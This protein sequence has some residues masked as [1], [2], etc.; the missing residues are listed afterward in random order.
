MKE[1]GAESR[2]E[3]R[4]RERYRIRNHGE[5]LDLAIQ[6]EQLGQCNSTIYLLPLL[7]QLTAIP[8]QR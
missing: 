5:L 6:Q 7:L 1:K 2:E 8:P 4:E 3:T